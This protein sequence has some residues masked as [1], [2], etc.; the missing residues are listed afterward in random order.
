MT[1]KHIDFQSSPV[2]RSLE[3]VALEKGLIKPDEIKKSASKVDLNPSGNLTQDILKLCQGLRLS[4][5]H[6]VAEEIEKKFI[7]Y[8]K[9]ENLSK[10]ILEEAHPEGSH[11]L[12]EVAGDALVE[13]LLDQHL[14]GIKIVEKKPTGKLALRTS[15]DIIKAAQ[16]IFKADSSQLGSI[17]N[18]LIDQLIGVCQ[19]IATK[20]DISE[21]IWIGRPHLGWTNR[22]LASQL[23]YASV[24]RHLNALIDNLSKEKENPPNIT[25]INLLFD[26]I[27]TIRNVVESTNSIDQNRK[28]RYFSILSSITDKINDFKKQLRGEDSVP[29]S[30]EKTETEFSLL[31]NKLGV[32]KSKLEGFKII[33]EQEEDIPEAYKSKIAGWLAKQEAIIRAME[34]K[35]LVSLKALP[36]QEEAK[37]VA[38]VLSNKIDGIIANIDKIKSSWGK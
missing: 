33:L 11:R 13:D 29:K 20:E 1:F 34:S 18:N 26:Y 8:K 4:G 22:Q 5:F 7:S 19:E 21:W 37:K 3:R 16:E 30:P 25:R 17:F 6:V 2:M 38:L 9:A 31:K 36:D 24:E 10:Q 35:S 23:S 15:R 14:A 27:S 32:V 28:T 12:K